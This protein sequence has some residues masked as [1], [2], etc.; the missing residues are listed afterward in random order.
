M[1]VDYLFCGFQGSSCIDSSAHFQILPINEDDGAMIKT[2]T[3]TK[4]RAQYANA[5]KNWSY[6]I[7]CMEIF[8]RNFHYSNKIYFKTL[9]FRI[10][11]MLYVVSLFK[12]FKLQYEIFNI[13]LK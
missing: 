4:F 7:K 9:L 3:I 13:Y 6:E 2:I 1:S 11:K 8:I 5:H 12:T 10:V